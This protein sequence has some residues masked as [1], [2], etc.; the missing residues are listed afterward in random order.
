MSRN[1]DRTT[2]VFCSG[3]VK[4]TSPPR[5]ATKADVGAYT[6]QFEG[7]IVADAECSDCEAKYLAWIDER[8]RI[9]NLYHNHDRWA[10]QERVNAEPQTHIDLSFRS[11]FD[12]EPGVEDLPKWR[13]VVRRERV[14]IERHTCGAPLAG[15]Y[16]WACY[17]VS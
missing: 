14:P 16:C 7:M 10:G 4:L 12:D 3:E 1:L 9:S 13:I 5:S 2:C 11:T 15:S 17:E 8:P 6:E